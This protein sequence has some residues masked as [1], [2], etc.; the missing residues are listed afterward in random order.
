LVPHNPQYDWAELSE[1]A[2]QYG[3]RN[4]TVLAM[5]P[6]ETSALIS[7]STNGIEPPRSLVT[8][9]G[10]KGALVKQVV[11]NPKLKYDYLWD[12]Q[13]PTGYINTMAVI[14]KWTDQAI[15][16][17]LSYNPEHYPEGK[18][19][20]AACVKDILNYW[21]LGGKNIYYMNQKMMSGEDAKQEDESCEACKL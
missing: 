18:L 19:N 1:Q 9:K 15:S 12:Q 17:N 7:N 13:T 3:V 2:K 6:A 14:Q 10:G 4:S 16:T 11:P 21:K 8:V 5:F 20:M